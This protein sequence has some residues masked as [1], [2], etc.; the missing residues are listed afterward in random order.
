MDTE[1][2]SHP[3]A[4]ASRPLHA[5]FAGAC[6]AWQVCRGVGSARCALWMDASRALVG[7]DA[8]VGELSAR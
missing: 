2:A 4:R 3:Y 8:G 6:G 7:G 5:P 1:R